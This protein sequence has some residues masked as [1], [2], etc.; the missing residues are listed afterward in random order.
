MKILVVGTGIIGSIFGWA[1]AEGGHDVTHFARS[2]KAANFSAGMEMDMIENRK[3]KKN[4]IGRYNIKV[5]ETL[6]PS[7]EYGAVIVPAKP[8]Q[9]A[10][11]LKQI[12]PLTGAADYLL[13]TQNWNGTMEQFVVKGAH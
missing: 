13:L 12:V 7:D 1:L 10:D 8:F 11:V 9:V 4:F 3:G 6:I 5:I 2:G